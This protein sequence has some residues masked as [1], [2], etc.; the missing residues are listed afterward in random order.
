MKEAQQYAL[1][2]AIKFFNSSLLILWFFFLIFGFSF[3]SG[4][5]FFSISLFLSFKNDCLCISACKQEK[6]S[7]CSL[8]H[9]FQEISYRLS[10][11]LVNSFFLLWL[12]F[13]ENNQAQENTLEVFFHAFFLRLKNSSDREQKKY[14]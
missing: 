12:K 14:V 4:F 8:F 2:K 13:G 3:S 11:A 7:N 5:N 6:N 1:S 9:P 10:V